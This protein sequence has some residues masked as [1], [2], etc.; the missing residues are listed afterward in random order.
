MVENTDGIKSLWKECYLL[1]FVIQD[2]V[3]TH[4]YNLQKTIL[5]IKSTY[6]KTCI[7]RDII[8]EIET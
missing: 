4:N 3:E 7:D 5:F 6:N 1:R 2:N 8:S